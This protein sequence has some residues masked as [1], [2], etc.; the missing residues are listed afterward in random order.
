MVAFPAG[1]LVSGR[2]RCT[3]AWGVVTHLSADCARRPRIPSKTTQRGRAARTTE[4]L[5]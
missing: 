1:K 5:R 2:A 3:R 4:H